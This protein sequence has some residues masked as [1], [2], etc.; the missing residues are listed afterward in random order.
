[1]VNGDKG[2]EF[3][4]FKINAIN[5]IIEKMNNV[6]VKNKNESTNG[7]LKKDISRRYTNS[8]IFNNVKP[9]KEIKTV[10]VKA[11]RRYTDSKI[12]D[13]LGS[14]ISSKKE[15]S[16]S[17]VKDISKKNTS[18]AKQMLNNKKKQSKTMDRWNS[19]DLEIDN[20]NSTII[21]LNEELKEISKKK[22]SVV[23]ELKTVIDSESK[24]LD[25]KRSSFKVVGYFGKRR[26]WY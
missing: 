21:K 23:N 18:D 2:L 26:E 5:E 6:V 7:S 4:M 16:T 12:F 9:K 20:I 19:F 22:R 14:K 13:G 10:E 3:K 11:K 17:V 25:I 1:M 15:I 24:K 8:D